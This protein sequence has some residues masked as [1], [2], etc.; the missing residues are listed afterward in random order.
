MDTLTQKQKIPF[1][2]QLDN[3]AD[4][5]CLNV[6]T[7]KGDKYENN[8]CLLLTIYCVSTAGYRV[9]SFRI[10]IAKRQLGDPLMRAFAILC[11]N[12]TQI[13][14]SI[15]FHKLISLK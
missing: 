5:A 8:V 1:I 2:K 13:I 4:I 7:S 9:H 12:L 3:G 15:T 11:E 6:I 14:I 10:S